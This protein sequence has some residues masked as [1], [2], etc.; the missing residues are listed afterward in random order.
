MNQVKP[1]RAVVRDNHIRLKRL[2]VLSPPSHAVLNV[3][4][5]NT[6]VDDLHRPIRLQA[7]SDHFLQQLRPGSLVRRHREIK[8]CRLAQ[9]DNAIALSFFCRNL[10]ATQ[11]AAVD[12]YSAF[13]KFTLATRLQTEGINIEGIRN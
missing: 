13:K 5:W 9:R 10:A 1:I 7:G 4:A 2:D 8:G 11:S 6:R 12:G 3:I